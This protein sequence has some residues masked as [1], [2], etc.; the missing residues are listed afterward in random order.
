MNC[1]TRLVQIFDPLGALTPV[2]ISA[3]KV[4]H[5]T[6]VATETAL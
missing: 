4:F 3:T 1:L 2:T 6:T 5:A